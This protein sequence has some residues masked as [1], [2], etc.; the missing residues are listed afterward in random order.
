[1]NVRVFLHDQGAALWP[2]WY[3][4]SVIEEY[5]KNDRAIFEALY[6][7]SPVPDAGALF[8]DNWWQRYDFLPSAEDIVASCIFVDS[9]FKDGVA[10]DYSVAA[11]WHRSADDK[12]YL[13]DVWRDQVK[14][15]E[16]V[17]EIHRFFLKH[18]SW[19]PTIYVEDAGSGQTLL[20][21]LSL[22]Y[23][24]VDLATGALNRLPS[25][26]VAA[27]TLP[28]GLKGRALSKTARFERV[29][30][31]ARAGRAHVPASSVNNH[32]LD[33]W[34]YEHKRVPF[35]SH[36][37]QADTT[38]MALDVFCGRFELQVP[39]DYR[40]IEHTATKPHRSPFK[41]RQRQARIEE[42][43]RQNKIWLDAGMITE[44]DII[45]D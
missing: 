36:H 2:Q 17:L 11:L 22:P 39:D 12:I 28:R 33:D 42:E 45:K 8:E 35:G 24:Y 18:K 6:Q 7:Q 10:N 23:A 31:H 30:H 20:Q 44:E 13:A 5:R 3:P 41:E 21:V 1:M 34:L 4:V 9:S 25:L 29:S 19:R 16:L 26:P 37:D 14:W 15:D 27:Y 43:D 38:A 40:L 32:W